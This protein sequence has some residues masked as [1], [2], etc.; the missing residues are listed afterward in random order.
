MLEYMRAG[1]G[2]MWIISLLSFVA[3]AVVLERLF[4]FTRS[5]T[6]PG[7]LEA[8]LARALRDGDL[9]TALVGAGNSSL[10]RLFAAAFSCWELPDETVRLL[11]ERRVRQELYRWER[12]LP[13]LEVTARVAPLLG[14]LGTVLGMV[15]MFRSLHQGG[16]V[17]AIA[18]TGGIWKALFTTVAGL[19]AAIP[20]VLAHSLLQ[21]AVDSQAETLERGVD[22]LLRERAVHEAGR[23]K[24]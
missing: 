1:G 24:S 10:H 6:D 19:I 14:L 16:A 18:V 11:A 17:D 13:I 12:H 23:P 2:I 5:R 7:R 22:F 20:M 8:G 9:E 4:F 3:L 15:E 21:G